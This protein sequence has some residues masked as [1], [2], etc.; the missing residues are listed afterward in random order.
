MT[1]RQR[2]PRHGRRLQ[3]VR[4]RAAPTARRG[5][6]ELVH[7]RQIHGVVHPRGRRQ[8]EGCLNHGAR[9]RRHDER[10]AKRRRVRQ[11]NG[12][13]ESRVATTERRGREL[14]GVLRTRMQHVG[15]DDEVD[16][17][18]QRVGHAARKRAGV[19]NEP[20]AQ[21]R[22]LQRQRSLVDVGAVGRDDAAAQHGTLP[23]RNSLRERHD[24]VDL[25]RVARDDDDDGAV[26]CCAR[27]AAGRRRHSDAKL[28]ARA[29]CKRER[30]QRPRRCRRWR[31]RFAAHVRA[32]NGEAI[33]FAR[34]GEIQWRR[35][36]VRILGQSRRQRE[37][38]RG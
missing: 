20:A 7:E 33:Q 4:D 16:A 19:Q 21:H 23:R 29:H 3:R 22:P 1:L 26:G 15:G 24:D 36:A 8:I 28:Q 17:V 18:E 25:R 35:R 9:R 13:C 6:A 14:E 30:R 5:H 12:L 11:H 27:I 32:R 34:P 10:A 31:Q 37:G 38:A 2:R